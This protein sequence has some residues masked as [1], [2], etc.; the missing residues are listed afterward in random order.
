MTNTVY[1]FDGN[2]GNVGVAP[3]SLP[4][5]DLKWETTEQWNLGLDLGFFDERI[6]FT[7]DLY[8]KTTRDLLLD[9]TLPYSSGYLTAMKN[10][11]KVRNDGI[12]LTLNTVNIDSKN[13][14]WSSNFN[15]SFNKN[16]VLELAENQTSLL[17]TARFDQNFNSQPNYIAKIGQPMGMIYGY[18]YEGTYKYDD[19]DKSGSSYTLK[20]N[21]PTT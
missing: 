19:F 11:G 16:K 6:S 15:I 12:E 4:N 5:E 2:N 18:I 14:K 13:F 8:R 9:A 21:F 1:P 20:G 17:S 10:I 7:A 3:I